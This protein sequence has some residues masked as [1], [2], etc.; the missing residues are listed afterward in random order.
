VLI[1][2]IHGRDGKMKKEDMGYANHLGLYS[3]EIAPATGDFLGNF[4]QAFTHIGFI[5]SALYL[6]KAAGIEQMGPPPI[7]TEL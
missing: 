3:E 4:S 2:L 7:G 5:N 1:D 6:G